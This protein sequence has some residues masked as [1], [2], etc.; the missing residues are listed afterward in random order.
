VNEMRSWH[1]AEFGAH[2]LQAVRKAIP[3]PGPGEVLIRVKSASLNYRDVLA[4][5]GTYLGQPPMP[6][7][8]GSDMAGE[9]AALGVGVTSWHIGQRVSANYYVDWLDGKAPRGMHISG[10]A[11]GWGLQGVLSD[12]IVVPAPAIVPIPPSMTFSEAS[13]LPIAGL[14]AWYSL[15]TEGG[16]TAG[17]VV[18]VLGTGGVSLFGMQFA[19]MFGARAIVT[20]RSAEKLEKV[21]ALGADATLD[22]SVHPDWSER[23]LS[24]TN[25]YGAD[26][27]LETLGGPSMAQSVAAIASG[28]QISLI[29]FL[30]GFEMQQSIVPLILT[31]SVT[32]GISVGHRRA[33][34]DMVRAIEANHMRPVIEKVYGFDEVPAAF[35]HM[36]KG[37]FGKIVIDL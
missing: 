20:S 26:H 9:I 24:L 19:K 16:L 27:I 33:F 8:P 13:T 4:L 3:E 6:F 17:D 21:L 18:L 29:G 12:Y 31:R 32:R 23:L 5:D 1:L 22:T 7:T 37:P 28:G 15:V 10:R 35:K 25:G 34:T 2:N 14:T 30:A 11:L 36:A